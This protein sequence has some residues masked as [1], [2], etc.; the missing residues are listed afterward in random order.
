MYK[1]LIKQEDHKYGSIWN[2]PILNCTHWNAPYSV[3]PI[4]KR[5]HRQLSPK[6]NAPQLNCTYVE[7]SPYWSAPIFKCTHTI[8]PIFKSTH[9]IPP[10]LIYTHVDLHPCL[11][12]PC[13]FAPMSICTHVDLHPS[14]NAPPCISTLI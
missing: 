12:A 5:T 3:A 11:F 7:I 8:S 6:L 1:L 10:M 13:Q 2:A 14:L 9:W 4:C